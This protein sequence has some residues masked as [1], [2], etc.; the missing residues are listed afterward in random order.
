MKCLLLLLLHAATVAA[1]TAS[2]APVAVAVCERSQKQARRQQSRNHVTRSLTRNCAH[3]PSAILGSSADRLFPRSRSCLG[4]R[5]VTYPRESEWNV[6]HTSGRTRNE[7]AYTRR[8]LRSP[9]DL[10]SRDR[11]CRGGG[12]KHH[13]PCI[14]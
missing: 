7:G 4:I 9:G 10:V 12:V 2:A 11:T 3:A 14:S 6:V 13:S 8:W 1:A 5:I